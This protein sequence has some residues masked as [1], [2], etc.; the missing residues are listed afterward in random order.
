LSRRR[1]RL[2]RC[3]IF[4]HRYRPSRHG[5]RSRDAETPWRHRSAA[6]PYRKRFGIRFCR[7]PHACIEV[8]AGIA[9]ISLAIGVDKPGIVQR[10]FTKT[11]IGNLADDAIVPSPISPC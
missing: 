8:A 2:A 6:R 7:F 5:R 3:R 4:L 1:Y 11:G 9:D 10:A